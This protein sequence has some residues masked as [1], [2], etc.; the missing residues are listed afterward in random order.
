MEIVKYNWG[1]AKTLVATMFYFWNKLT[2]KKKESLSHLRTQVIFVNPKDVKIEGNPDEDKFANIHKIIKG[3]ATFEPYMRTLYK[4]F[5]TLAIS[6][7]LNS[8]YPL[9]AKLSSA[10]SFL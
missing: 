8:N 6:I 2:E 7:G 10:W 5:H 1:V 3:K 9:L 4:T